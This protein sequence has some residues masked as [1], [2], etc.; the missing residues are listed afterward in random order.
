MQAPEKLDGETAVLAH[1]I[2]SLDDSWMASSQVADAVEQLQGGESPD[3][4]VLRYDRH[5]LNEAAAIL[6][7]SIQ[8]KE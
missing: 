3:T 4:V 7:E 5:V 2:A 1:D 8:D 6:A